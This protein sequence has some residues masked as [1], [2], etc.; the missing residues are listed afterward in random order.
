MR[1]NSQVREGGAPENMAS[2]KT[3]LSLTIEETWSTK[4]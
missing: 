3:E 4:T 2:Q 1:V